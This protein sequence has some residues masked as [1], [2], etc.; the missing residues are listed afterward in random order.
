MEKYAGNIA[1]VTLE[2]VHLPM[3]VTRQS[4]KLD[5]L[6]VGGGGQ[7]FHRWVE[8]DPINA[9][10][11]TVKNVLYLNLCTAHDFLRTAPSFLHR[12]LF[13]LEEVPDADSLI[14][15]ATGNEGVLWVELSTH[16]VV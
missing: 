13:K 14:Q 7:N 4:P 3:F 9:F 16:D 6:V 11:V 1:G 5:C 8:R 12:Q 10:L 15:T 2:G